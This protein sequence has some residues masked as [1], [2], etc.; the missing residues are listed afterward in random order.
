MD[1]GT[2]RRSR[3]GDVQ[4][5]RRAMPVPV[6]VPVA[7]AESCDNPNAAAT[8]KSISSTATTLPMDCFRTAGV[9]V[10]RGKPAKRLVGQSE[11]VPVPVSASRG[12]RVQGLL[13]P[14]ATARADEPGTGT[15]AS[16]TFRNTKLCGGSFVPT[17]ASASA[18]PN[19]SAS[20]S[21]SKC[22][23]SITRRQATGQPV[24]VRTTTNGASDGASGAGEG[25]S[26]GEGDWDQAARARA[27]REQ[28]ALGQKHRKL[29]RCVLLLL[30]SSMHACTST[31]CMY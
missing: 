9:P 10:Q 13:S 12:K 5:M 24:Q 25:D 18:G 27:L 26:D 21:A 8:Y 11:P 16:K 23:A 20:A 30:N 4:G 7:V 1:E 29:Y 2:T 22:G 15:S 3:G 28:R 6:P 19:A 31:Y 14:Y 17:T